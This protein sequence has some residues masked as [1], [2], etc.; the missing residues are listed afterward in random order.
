MD[1]V[2]RIL[3]NTASR[4]FASDLAAAMGWRVERRSRELAGV[5]KLSLADVVAEIELHKSN[6]EEAQA[7]A[8]LAALLD[9]LS[10]NTSVAITPGSVIRIFDEQGQLRMRFE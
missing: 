9:G 8:I 1:G 10:Q 5:E 6:G 4:G 2:R 7:E 3:V